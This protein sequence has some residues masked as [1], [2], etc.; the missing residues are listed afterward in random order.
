[1]TFSLTHEQQASLLEAMAKR[2]QQ[3][4]ELEAALH[5]I[6]L[7]ET[8]QRPVRPRAADLDHQLTAGAAKGYRIRTGI[9]GQ[10]PKPRGG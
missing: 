2:K 3:E 10:P 9:R 7:K 4:I 6:K 5:G 8:A 1:M